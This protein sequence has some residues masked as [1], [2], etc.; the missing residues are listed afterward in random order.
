MRTR[1][2][3]THRSVTSPTDGTALCGGGEAALIRRAAV[4]AAPRRRQAWP[5]GPPHGADNVSVYTALFVTLDAQRIAL[6]VA[7]FLVMVAVCRPTPG[8]S[9]ATRKWCRR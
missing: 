2:E 6:S 5:S 8:W 4:P 1:R 9:G 3:P 7:V